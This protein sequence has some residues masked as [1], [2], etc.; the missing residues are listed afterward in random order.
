MAKQKK[1][2]TTTPK[3]S[4]HPSRGVAFRT[5]WYFWQEIKRE[6]WFSL[7]ML[8]VT[9][10]V[11]FFRDFYFIM[12]LASIIDKV[13]SGAI[14]QDQLWQTLAPE[15]IT[16]VV[17]IA[18][19]SIVFEKLRLWF[20]WK[21]ELRSMYKLSSLVFNTLCTQSMS[22]HNDRFGGSLVSQTN[23]FVGAFE[24]LIDNAVWAIMPLVCSIIFTIT[25]LNAIFEV[26]K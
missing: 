22:F 18:F 26:S 12:V 15:A 10:M 9:P 14:P 11:I 23:R 25:S 21:M 5:L 6:K 7:G 13:S 8:I 3:K 4:K 16:L 2:T 1:P 24:R 17:I 20:C 19:S